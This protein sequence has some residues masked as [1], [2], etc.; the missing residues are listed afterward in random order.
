THLLLGHARI[1]AHQQ[2]ARREGPGTP[3]EGDAGGRGPRQDT[4]FTL[5]RSARPGHA[6][7]AQ[8]QDLDSTGRRYS[9]DGRVGLL[10]KGSDAGWAGR[11]SRAARRSPLAVAVRAD[12]PDL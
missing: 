11:A 10:V 2:Q 5:L 1:T 6:R 7:R 3:G 9:E 8:L 4:R 12:R